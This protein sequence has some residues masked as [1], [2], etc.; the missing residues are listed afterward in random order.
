VS[1]E[2]RVNVRGSLSSVTSRSKNC[3]VIG[4]RTSCRNRT[5]L[6]VLELNR[7]LDNYFAEVEQAAFSPA[8]VVP[9]ISFSPDKMLQGRLFS[10]GDTHRYGLGINFNQ[11]L[12][13]ALKCPFHSYHRDGQMRT[14]GSPGATTTYNPNSQGL[15]TTSRN[16]LIYHSHSMVT[17]ITMTTA[18]RRITG[19]NRAISSGK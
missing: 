11:I 16:M 8:N 7:Y 19:N 18:L 1:R 15:W 17:R 13:N 12:V 10:Y 5:G 14:D 6:G 3:R 9:G 2:L 4:H